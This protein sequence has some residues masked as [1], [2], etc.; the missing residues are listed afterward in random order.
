MGRLTVQIETQRRKC[1]A[2]PA[3]AA[4]QAAEE[5]QR[6]GLPPLPPT[7]GERWTARRRKAR[8]RT[9]AAASR[10]REQ[11]LQQWTVWVTPQERGALLNRLR[12]LRSPKTPPVSG[13]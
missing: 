11:G 13:E 10:R 4:G 7:P 2:N 9:A 5:R 8:E 3:Q 6:R 12:E 1:E